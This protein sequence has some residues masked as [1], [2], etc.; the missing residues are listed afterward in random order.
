M[1]ASF[2]R[3]KTISIERDRV[4][5]ATPTPFTADGR[6]DVASVQRMVAHHVDLGVSGF[7]LAGTDRKSVV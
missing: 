5:S 7:M 2:T 1:A 3:M 6:V 4:W